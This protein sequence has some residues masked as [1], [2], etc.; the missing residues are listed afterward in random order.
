LNFR[1]R[2]QLDGRGVKK[3]Y[4][5]FSAGVG[6]YG[7]VNVQPGAGYTGYPSSCARR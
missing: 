6:F 3:G 7:I 5:G 1:Q 2:I 4:G